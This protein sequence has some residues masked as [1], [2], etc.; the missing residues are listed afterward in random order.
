MPRSTRTVDA[1]DRGDGLTLD[2]ELLDDA[3]AFQQ[4]SSQHTTPQAGDLV[5][6]ARRLRGAGSVGAALVDDVATPG[7]E[8]AAGEVAK[9]ARHGAG[10]RGQRLAG[11]QPARQRADQAPGVG[12][13]R[14][15][16]D[17]ARSEP[18]STTRPAYSTATRSQ[19]SLTTSRLCVI[20]RTPNPS[21]F[22]RSRISCQDLLRDRDVERGGRLI[23]N[24]QLGGRTA[25]R[26]RSSPAAASR[27]RAR[28]G[29]AA[30]TRSASGR[31]TRSSCAGPRPGLGLATSAGAGAAPAASATPTVKTGLNAVPG[32][33]KT[34]ETAAPRSCGTLGARAA[35]SRSTPSKVDLAGAPGALAAGG[36]ARRV[37]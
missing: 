22:F 9:I 35:A 2:R 17:A 8:G 4:G 3:A 36:R 27:R 30:A 37:R 23:H 15:G 33:W 5:A 31:P 18:T 21:S 14:R 6:R 7:R 24:Q 25:A 34:I 10:D 16:Q 28:A 20:S 32:F 11:R 29:T 12:V 19:T 13:R 26:S 1:V